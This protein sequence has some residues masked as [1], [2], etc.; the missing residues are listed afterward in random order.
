VH[1][2]DVLMS[3]VIAGR[4]T[5]A[6]ALSWFFDEMTRHPEVEER[7]VNCYLFSP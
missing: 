4:D 5:T 2:R 1:L 7:F 3:F 6:N